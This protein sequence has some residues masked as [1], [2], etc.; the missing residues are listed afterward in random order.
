MKTVLKVAGMHC[1]SCAM[2]IE[3]VLSDEGVTSK[4]NF[5]TGE[6]IVDFDEKKIK[7]SRIKELIESEAGYKIK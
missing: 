5:K 2:L 7:L 3:D 1:P 4:A 6:V